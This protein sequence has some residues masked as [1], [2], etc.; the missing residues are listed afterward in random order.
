MQPGLGLGLLISTQVLL[1]NSR[2]DDLRGFASF[3]MIWAI[4]ALTVGIGLII[5]GVKT[6]NGNGSA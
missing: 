6:K 1:Q 5:Y 2:N 4:P 3:L